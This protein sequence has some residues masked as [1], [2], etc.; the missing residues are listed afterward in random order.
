MRPA[1]LNITPSSPRISLPTA[2]VLRTSVPRPLVPDVIPDRPDVRR[3]ALDRDE[4]VRR[5]F[6]ELVVVRFDR[7]AVELVP[8]AR[9]TNAELSPRPTKFPSVTPS[10]PPNSMLP[11]SEAVRFELVEVV[12]F[13]LLDEVELVL[14]SVGVVPV[15]GSDGVLVP[16]V[17]LRWANT[18]VVLAQKTA[19]HKTET[20]RRARSVRDITNSS[21]EK[22]CERDEVSI[23]RH[24]F[25]PPPPA[26]RSRNT[27]ERN[28]PKR[29]DFKRSTDCKNG[30]G[31]VK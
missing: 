23:R 13:E 15:V 10:N 26:L 27:K 11:P 24:K 9:P 6:G 30:A 5:T 19:T 8:T 2:A 17:S 4:V 14:G 25:R 3:L 16:P 1:R 20:E 31:C 22:F 12:E 21:R 18:M 7:A 28:I 29:G